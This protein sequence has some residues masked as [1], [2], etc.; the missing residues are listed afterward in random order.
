L[1]RLAGWLNVRWLVSLA[2]GAAVSAVAYGGRALTLDGALAATLVGG[3]TFAC[4]GISAAAALLAFFASS[5][6]LSRLGE[7]K[8]QRDG[9]L[10]QAKGGR[11]DAWQVL[12]NGGWATLWLGAFGQRGAGGFLGALAVAAA[13]TWGTEVGMLARHPPR[14]ITSLRVVRPGTS[15]GV[16]LEGL[17]AGAGGAL[18]V[19]LAWSLAG[20]RERLRSW[21]LVV[22]AGVIGSLVDSL[23]GA[24]VQALYWCDVCAAPTEQPAHP[25]CGRPAHRVRGSSWVDND[26]VNGLATLCGSLVGA[27]LWR[28]QTRRIR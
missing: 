6:L 18:A 8:K 15:G 27:A 5:S 14:L 3:V 9:V 25:R 23:L 2:L 4:G 20:G 16:T 19:G 7:A 22:T 13:D 17:A 1:G 12:A 10:A 26:V 11:R 28:A 24:T 21:R